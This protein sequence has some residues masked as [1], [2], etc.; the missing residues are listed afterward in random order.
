ML[1]RSDEATEGVE[2]A[3]AIYRPVPSNGSIAEATADLAACR[4]AA[5]R[6]DEAIETYRDAV[7]VLDTHTLRNFEAAAPRTGLAEALLARAERTAE[8]AARS[9]DLDEAAGSAALA[10]K[11]AKAFRPGFPNAARVT[12]IERWLRGDQAGA[13]QW[14]VRGL[15]SARAMGARYDE[16]R[17]QQDMGRLSG[18]VAA[19]Q[20]GEGIMGEIVTSWRA[21]A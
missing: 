14:W 21:G 1:F 4:L 20:A 11:H 16:A 6:T 15:E 10:R 9:R 7:A 12:G 3:L 5:G 18:D 8:A 13:K 19:A 2:A 17:I